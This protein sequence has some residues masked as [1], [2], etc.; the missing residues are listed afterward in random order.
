MN[1]LLFLNGLEFV[2]FWGYSYSVVLF[3]CVRGVSSPSLTRAF[4][5][6]VGVDFVFCAVL[7]VVWL[8]IAFSGEFSLSLSLSHTQHTQHTQHTLNTLVYSSILTS[9]V[10]LLICLLIGTEN[11]F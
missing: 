10:I 4:L 7:M 11:F 1:P 6:L 8:I 3:F 2:L 5:K 9:F